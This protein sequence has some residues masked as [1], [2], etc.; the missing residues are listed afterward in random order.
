M[1]LFSPE[2]QV[3]AEWERPG[4]RVC[5][6]GEA[7]QDEWRQEPGEELHHHRH[8]DQQEAAVLDVQVFQWQGLPRVWRHHHRLPLLVIILSTHFFIIHKLFILFH[9]YYPLNTLSEVWPWYI[10]RFI[11]KHSCKQ[12]F[13]K[14]F[15]SSSV[16]LFLHQL[17]F[18]SSISML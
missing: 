4:Q 2:Y 5:A 17:A 9:I 10:A 14:S 11:P 12:N 6:G 13:S 7:G 16:K 1:L 18:F 8:R 3:S 15:K